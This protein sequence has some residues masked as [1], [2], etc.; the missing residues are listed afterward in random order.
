[1]PGLLAAA[2][3]RNRVLAALWSVLALWALPA[4]A[5]R[6][7]LPSG[8]NGEIRIEAGP[9]DLKLAQ[10]N[11]LR[12]GSDHPPEIFFQLKAGERL[13]LSLADVPPPVQFV[14][15]APF[16]LWIEE[17]GQKPL[18]WAPDLFHEATGLCLDG[19]LHLTSLSGA[20]QEISVIDETRKSVLK[21]AMK[22]FES[23]DL[24]CPGGD[25][26]IQGS[27][28]WSGFVR[29][30]SGEALPLIGQRASNP[31]PRPAP[32]EALFVLSDEAQ[33]QEFIVR[34]D[35]PELIAQARRQIAHPEEFM[36]RILVAEI[37]AGSRS[38]NQNLRSTYGH[39]WSWHVKTVFRFAE[40][41]SQVCDGNPS[42]V[43][44]LLPAWLGGRMTGSRPLICFWSY[45]IVREL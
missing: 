21:L 29:K 18:P 7:G 8:L 23:T 35:N 2:F 41:A 19:H 32:G 27:A 14:G 3:V 39:Y 28:P 15:S 37:A 22:A 5:G 33:S 4:Q 10:K 9:R 45:R 6:V 11:P 1:M 38:E 26:R 42:F 31:P 16:Q 20:D 24:P 25:L 44:D 12:E 17:P 34:L 13:R 43:E 36:A 30:L 40:L